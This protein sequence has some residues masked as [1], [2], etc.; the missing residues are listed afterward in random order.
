MLDQ[1]KRMNKTIKNINSHLQSSALQSY[2][3][4]VVLLWAISNKE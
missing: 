3:A 2:C 1:S 4:A